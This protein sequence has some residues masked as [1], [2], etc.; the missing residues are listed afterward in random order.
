MIKIWGQYGVNL[1]AVRDMVA[2]NFTFYI[3]AGSHVRAWFL[4]DCIYVY[5][6]AICAVAAGH[7]SA[8]TV[9]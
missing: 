7:Y 1:L 6:V 8:Y 4:Y 3:F 9:I 5:V 2:I